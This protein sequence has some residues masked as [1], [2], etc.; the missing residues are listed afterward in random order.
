MQERGWD[1]LAEWQRDNP[2]SI[3]E[4]LTE[5]DVPSYDWRVRFVGLEAYEPAGGA[6]RRDLFELEGGGTVQDVA[7]LETLVRGKLEAVADEVKAEGW[8][9]TE[10]RLSLGW[11]EQKAFLCGE[12]DEAALSEDMQAEAR[13]LQ[14]EHD[15]LRNGAVMAIMMM[16][17]AI[18]TR[19]MPTRRPKRGCRPSRNG[20]MR[21]RHDFASGLTNRRPAP[22][23]SSISP[24]GAPPKSSAA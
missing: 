23:P 11:D 1:G 2:R 7:L 20:S 5:F 8:N 17:T 12:P 3:R 10:A 21:R 4:A 15:A 24:I 6:V 13:Q 14:A 16:M 9:W 22:V 19:P 18:M